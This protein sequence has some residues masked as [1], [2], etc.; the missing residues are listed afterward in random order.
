[1]RV[2]DWLIS[3]ALFILVSSLALVCFVKAFRILDQLLSLGIC[4][5]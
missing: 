2:V 4:H 3:I 5:D 1:M